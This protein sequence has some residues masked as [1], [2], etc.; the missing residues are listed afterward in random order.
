[1]GDLIA[2][3]LSQVPLVC[4][5]APQ[6]GAVTSITLVNQHSEAE[7]LP[8]L[9]LLSLPQP[10]STL[11]LEW[12]P[13]SLHS[14]PGSWKVRPLTAP[15]DLTRSRGKVAEA[16]GPWGWAAMLGIGDRARS[17]GDREWEKE[18]ENKPQVRQLHLKITS[19]SDLE[20]NPN[21]WETLS[22]HRSSPGHKDRCPSILLD[23]IFGKKGGKHWIIEHLLNGLFE[24]KRGVL[25]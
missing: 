16:C 24:N 3:R 13:R 22:V 14:W 15:G 23:T 17:T 20:T 1:M 25:F 11:S 10:L 6:S 12:T 19:A 2:W 9:A 5:P 18:G 8:K 7:K 21:H 4:Q